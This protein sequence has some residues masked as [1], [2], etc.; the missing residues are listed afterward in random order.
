M[1]SEEKVKGK[2]NSKGKDLK[3][4]ARHSQRGGTST[5]S[6]KSQCGKKDERCIPTKASRRDGVISE[7]EK[8]GWKEKRWRKKNLMRNVK[9][10]GGAEKSEGT[11]K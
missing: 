6:P 1:K 10:V 9:I 2:R 3:T 8:E 5:P 4:H 7:E 11:R